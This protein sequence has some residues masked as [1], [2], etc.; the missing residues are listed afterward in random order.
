MLSYTQLFPATNTW[1]RYA[2]DSSRTFGMHDIAK[3]EMVIRSGSGLSVANHN[4]RQR[5]MAQRANHKNAI[6]L[7]A[8]LVLNA[9]I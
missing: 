5:E 3:C 9:H 6:L 2:Q 8:F 7:I 4:T 1:S